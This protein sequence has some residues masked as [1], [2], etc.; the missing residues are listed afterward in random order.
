MALRE[1]PYN[2]LFTKGLTFLK[3]DIKGHFLQY[4][5]TRKYMGEDDTIRFSENDTDYRCKKRYNGIIRTEE[6]IPV[7]DITELFFNIER[8]SLMKSVFVDIHIHT[9]PNPNKPN[10][11]Y[12]V[13]VLVEKVNEMAKGQPIILSLT[14]HNMLNKKAYLDLCGKVDC[15]LL[16]VELHIRKYDDAPPYHCHAIFRDEVSEKN[17][18]EINCILDRLYPNKE[19]TP[20]TENVPHIE[21]IANAFDAYD[22]ML[23]PHGGQSHK[24]FD[25]ATGE[26]HRFDTSMEQSLYYNHFEGFT[27]RSNSGLQE[28]IEYFTKLGIDQFINLITCSDNY[29]PRLYPSPK[30]P[31]A[32]AFIPTWIFSQPSFDGLRMALS[33][34]SR[35]HYGNT[36][37]EEWNQVIYGISLKEENCDIDV[38]LLPGLNV[39]IGGSSSGKTLF[40][41]SMVNGIKR[42]F[43]S[44]NYSQ[45]GIDK[46]ITPFIEKYTNQ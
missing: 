15:V 31:T 28:T 26:G 38:K 35:I 12:E 8:G 5:F 9:S 33:E 44:N 2:I 4:E 42:D 11:K 37:P 34:K 20:T 22:F 46:V 21:D 41:E 24:T 23:L 17:I 43:S 18:D 29:N 7:I 13:D 16:G 10:D 32:E 30:E 39:V 14:D 19:V 45:F 36:A 40:V 1:T 25:K 3:K 27:A 6:S